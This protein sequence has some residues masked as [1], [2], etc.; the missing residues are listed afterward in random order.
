M[1]RSEYRFGLTDEKWEAAKGEVRAA[2]LDAAWERRMTSYGE[3]A[4]AVTA[5]DLEAHSGL[6]NH[7]LGEI[8]EEE[9][10]AGRPALTSIVTHKD[11]D[12]EPGP[13]FYDMARSLGYRF[14]EAFV[15]WSGQVQEVFKLHGRPRRGGTG[16]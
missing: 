13:G 15:F 5:T 4:R 16:T 9:H 2:I 7:L 6:M 11:G 8:F 3:V 10:T 14:D 12:K 1:K